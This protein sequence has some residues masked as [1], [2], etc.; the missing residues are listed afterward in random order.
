MS[1]H[2]HKPYRDADGVIRCDNGCGLAVPRPP[3]MP[4]YRKAAMGRW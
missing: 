3:K 2:E 4:D 1:G